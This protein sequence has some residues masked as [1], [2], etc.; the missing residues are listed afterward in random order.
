VRNV[1]RGGDNESGGEQVDGAQASG[2]F[3]GAAIS[4]FDRNDQL[5]RSVQGCRS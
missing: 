4:L 5:A 3:H 2:F 1:E